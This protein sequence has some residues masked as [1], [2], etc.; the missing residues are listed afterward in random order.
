[1]NF[2]ENF[3]RNLKALMEQR[4][5]TDG[6]L[7]EKIGMRQPQ[8]NRY[9]NGHQEPG[10]ETLEKLC[11]VFGVGPA[12]LLGKTVPKASAPPTQPVERERLEAISLLLTADPGTVDNALFLL[13]SASLPPKQKRKPAVG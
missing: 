3:Q 5:L 4:G 1:M 7:A 13:R 6:Q 10:M 9:K 12:D 8:L 11:A 2:F